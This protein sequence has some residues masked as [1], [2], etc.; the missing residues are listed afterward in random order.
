VATE[1]EFSRFPTEG[2]EASGEEPARIGGAESQFHLLPNGTVLTVGARATLEDAAGANRGRVDP[3]SLLYAALRRAPSTAGSGQYGTARELLREL[4]QHAPARAITRLATA[5]DLLGPAPAGLP[6]IESVPG[7]A[8]LLGPAQRFAA[9]T[10]VIDTV[11]TRHLLAAAVTAEP[12]PGAVLDAFDVS[13]DGLCEALYRAVRRA[14]PDEPMQAWV[15]ILL[16]TSGLVELTGGL[17][18]DHMDPDT[19]L[20]LS[21]DHLGVSTYVS[22]L[23]SVIARA[24]TPL[25][26]SIGLFG[27]WGSGKTY[28]MSLLREQVRVLSESDGPGYRPKIVQIGFNAW[29]YA[30]TNLWAS[31]GNEI[32]GQLAKPGEDRDARFLERLRADLD[33]TLQRATE[34][35]DAKDTA[36]K[37]TVR[38]REELDQARDSR[39]RSTA[40]LLAAA[41]GT[42]EA[43]RELSEIWQRLGIDDKVEQSALLADEIRG[44]RTDAS[45][46]R[47]VLGGRRALWLVVLAAAVLAVVGGAIAWPGAARW[48]AGGGLVG[49]A[50][51][52]ATGAALLG[53]VRRG[54][55]G[56]T[57]FA[58]QVRNTAVAAELKNLRTAEAQE[59][60]VAAELDEVLARAGELGRELAAFS[61]GRRLYSFLT[62]RAGSEDYRRELGV[63][64][65]VRRDF[66]QLMTLMKAW[67]REREEPGGAAVPE[68]IGRIVLYIDDLDRCSPRQVVD[69]LQAVHLLLALDLFVVVVGVD[70]RWL[71]HSL[72]QQYPDL[73]GRGERPWHST[74]QDYLEK[75]FNIPFVLP[76]MTAG[77]F[78]RLIRDL[79]GVG[80]STVDTPAPSIA[81]DDETPGDSGPIVRYNALPAEPAAPAVE[82]RSEVAA[83]RQ[84]RPPSLQ[85]LTEPELQLIAALAPLV[86]SPREAKRLLN[87]YR[88]LRSTRDLSDASTFLDGEYQAVVLLLGVLIAH[89]GRFGDFLHN[90]LLREDRTTSWRAF[91]DGL[92]PGLAAGLEPATS[93]VTL[94]D[95]S[96]LHA[97]GPHIARFSFVLAA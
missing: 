20:P 68:P 94:E 64:S 21:R 39:E 3:T 19:H 6:P 16:P 78:G 85:P 31:L 40:A 30:D 96:A 91:V 81:D 73:L 34:L 69:V 65:T 23:A 87:L 86:R 37:V 67:E 24:D 49:L 46:L 83:I 90:R 74:P 13:A 57:R 79:S 63:I 9:R 50:T 8:D 5:A 97:W 17:S 82:A 41:A 93:L 10:G 36:Q 84:G 4:R 71:E 42:D 22:M 53:R 72:R 76:A 75:I 27:E 35:K 28:F 60:I 26:L 70:P 2:S 59:Q 11:H 89:P 95:L 7:V 48:L 33:R 62:E 44:V 12:A 61:P 80:E 58:R 52:L 51:V 92:E 18:A 29:T 66:Q 55:R 14:K 45:G 38:L 43:K 54:L 77:S 56:L 88:I 15:E 47:L 32:F 25:P 1:S